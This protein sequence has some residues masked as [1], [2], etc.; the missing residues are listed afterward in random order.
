M[1]A[2]PS[3]RAL[4]VLGALTFAITFAV[5][6]RYGAPQSGVGRFFYFAVVLVALATGQCFGV[7]AGA[8]AVVFYAIGVV[9]NP[10]L[11]ASELTTSDNVIRALSYLGLGFLVG[12]FAST[13]RELTERL[14]LLSKVDPVTGIA[15][16]RS[17]EEMI[18]RHLERDAR[19]GLFIVE[20]SR[21]DPESDEEQEFTDD[22]LQALSTRLVRSVG[23]TAEVART[24]PH[25]FAVLITG[26]TRPAETATRLERLLDPVERDVVVGWA[27]HPADGKNALAL[28]RAA[29]ERLYV[30]RLLRTPG[31]TARVGASSR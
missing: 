30:R 7:V 14:R 26:G 22:Q 16:L 23:N 31:A 10:H 8:L 15:S 11:P 13:S 24:G 27:V 29:A 19:F 9:I 12:W 21:A 1:P 17:F 20:C 18:T 25:E 28:R 5:F 6:A 2:A 4:A 3:R